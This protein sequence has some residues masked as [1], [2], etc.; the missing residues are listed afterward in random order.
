MFRG[1]CFGVTELLKGEAVKRRDEARRGKARSKAGRK[2]R[3]SNI[4]K[5]LRSESYYEYMRL[6]PPALCTHISIFL[7]NR[8]RENER[9]EAESR[10]IVERMT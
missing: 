3:S 2:E 10:G 1:S 5:R 8:L 6:F 4:G 9:N 7:N